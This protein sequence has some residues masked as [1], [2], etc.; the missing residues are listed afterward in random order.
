MARP[1]RVVLY[2]WIAASAT[3]PWLSCGTDAVGVDTCRDIEAAR[4]EAASHCPDIFEIDD[5]QACRFYY[6]DQCLHGLAIEREP[7]APLVR[8]CVE[9]IERAGRCADRDTPLGECGSLE[10]ESNGATSVCELIQAPELMDAC[11][12]L[13]P[14]PENGKDE[15]QEETPEESSEAG[16]AGGAASGE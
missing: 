16:G 10:Q 6:R 7:G 13:V 3:L 11:S 1:T 9:A 5:V 15:E 14:A 4:C 12:F 8:D 2:R